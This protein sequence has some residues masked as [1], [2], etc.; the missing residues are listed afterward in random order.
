MW[1]HNSVCERKW[2]LE[3]APGASGILVML[4]EKASSSDY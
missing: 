3:N 2:L 1:P 4:S